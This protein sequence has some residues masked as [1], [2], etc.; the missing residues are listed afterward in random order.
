MPS[1][2][3]FPLQQSELVV[4]GSPSGMQG[5]SPGQQTRLPSESG[6][7]IKQQHWSGM[8]HGSRSS[9]H[10]NPDS[11]VSVSSLQSPLQQSLSSVQ[12]PPSRTQSSEKHRMTPYTVSW[13]NTS[14]SGLGQPDSIAGVLQRQQ[15]WGWGLVPHSSPAGAHPFGLRH[16]PISAFN[17]SHTPGPPK[18]GSLQHS[19]S[20]RHNSPK[21]RQPPRYWQDR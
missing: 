11:Q 13:Q 10:S 15:S 5:S 18:A 21:G 19:A 6:A 14:P 4:Q 9:K 8:A 16:R 20:D 2:L 1:I 7:Q 3:Q 12:G 17:I